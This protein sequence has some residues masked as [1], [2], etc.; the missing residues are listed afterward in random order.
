MEINLDL[1]SL[2]K[3]AKI[4]EDKHA[5]EKD[6]SKRLSKHLNLGSEAVTIQVTNSYLMEYMNYIIQGII[7]ISCELDRNDLYELK[8]ISY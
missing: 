7:L 3:K 2:C 5:E 1:V 8:Y 4:E 6:L